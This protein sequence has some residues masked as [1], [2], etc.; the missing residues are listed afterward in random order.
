MHQSQ[1]HC[2]LAA[3]NGNKIYSTLY[4]VFKNLKKKV[5]TSKSSIVNVL[6]LIF[7]DQNDS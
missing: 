4:F 5:Y 3:K 1:M 7:V 6:S 2:S